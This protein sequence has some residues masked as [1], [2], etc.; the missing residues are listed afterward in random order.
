MV[1]LRRPPS[2]GREHEGGDMSQVALKCHHKEFAHQSDVFPAG[3]GLF[4]G[5]RDVRSLVD[6]VV[7]VQLLNLFFDLSH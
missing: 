5:F 7:L 3:H 2:L 4:I 1:E 6:T